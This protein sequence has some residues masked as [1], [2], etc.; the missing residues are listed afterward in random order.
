MPRKAKY[1]KYD[2]AVRAAIAMTGRLDLFPELKI[3][4]MTALYWIKERFSTEDPALLP[5]TDA[6]NEAQEKNDALSRGS[7]ESEAI[8]ELLQRVFKILGFRL[9]WKHIDSSDKKM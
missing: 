2:P 8:I 9:E 6:I 1:K 3:P 4:R 5:L 7:L